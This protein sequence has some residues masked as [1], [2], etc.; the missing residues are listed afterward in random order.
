M[1]DL[2]FHHNQFLCVWTNNSHVGCIPIARSCSQRKVSAIFKYSELLTYTVPT[3]N[4]TLYTPCIIRCL[5]LRPEDR[6]TKW[7]CSNGSVSDSL[8]LLML[9]SIVCVELCLLSSIYL[10]LRSLYGTVLYICLWIFNSQ[11]QEGHKNEGWLSDVL[12]WSMD[13]FSEVQVIH[14]VD[15]MCF[16]FF[17]EDIYNVTKEFCFKKTFLFIKENRS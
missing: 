6:V 3:E 10:V 15:Q 16:F 12:Y 17:Y 14:S 2:L 4:C 7:I 11:Q 8:L 1:S 13:T 5:L 9:S